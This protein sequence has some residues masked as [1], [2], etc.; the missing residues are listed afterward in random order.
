MDSIGVQPIH[1]EGYVG[2]RVKL[3]GFPLDDSFKRG[4]VSYCR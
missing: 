1:N 3:A 2:I 4:L